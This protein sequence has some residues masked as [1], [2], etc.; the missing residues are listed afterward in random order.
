MH[1]DMHTL[2]QASEPLRAQATR[3]QLFG[4]S[5]SGIGSLALASLLRREAEADVPPASQLT[6]PGLPSLPH[7]E[8]RA[9]R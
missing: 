6:V 2:W 7:H 9:K 4:A 3:R 1:S 5:A 8:P